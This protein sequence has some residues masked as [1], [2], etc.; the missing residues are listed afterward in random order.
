MDEQIDGNTQDG[1]DG[2][3]GLEGSAVAAEGAAQA[4]ATPQAGEDTFLTDQQIMEKIRA[5]PEL[6]HVFTK[7]QGSF[8]RRMQQAAKVRDS[9]AIV[10]RFNS[11]PDFARQTIL[12]RASQLG[13]QVGGQQTGQTQPPQGASV[14][15]ELV[16]SVR[17]QLGDELKWMAPMLAAS[18]WAGMQYALGPIKQQQ[19]DTLRSSFDQQFDHLAESLSEKSPGWE[20]YEDDMDGL[21]AFLKSDK[22]TDRRW[23]SK[24]ELLFR[25]V[26]GPGVATAQ[27]AQR[28]AQAG[29][30]KV[31]TGQATATTA[32]DVSEQVKKPKNMQDA[33]DIAAK[34]AVSVL[35]KQGIKVS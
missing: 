24:L 19:A 26:V 8:T 31:S 28:M 10:E 16:E 25:A 7:M 17:G 12:Q 33:W 3:Q 6:N 11:D 2:A 22:M 34:H 32:P 29:K 21:L 9:A 14:P 18:Q 35:E 27:A 23:G 20:Q 13:M 4:T 30:N 5:N 1:S 15:P